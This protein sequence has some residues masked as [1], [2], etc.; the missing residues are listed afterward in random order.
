MR[1][2]GVDNNSSDL[3]QSGAPGTDGLQHDQPPLK[4]A[5]RPLLHTMYR[6]ALFPF[7]FT[8]HLDWQ[9]YRP[10]PIDCSTYDS[11]RWRRNR[12][13]F[14]LIHNYSTWCCCAGYRLCLPG[15][16]LGY[17]R[18]HRCKTRLE[19]EFCFSL[20]FIGKAN[21]QNFPLLSWNTF[22]ENKII[23]PKLP[24]KIYFRLQVYHHKVN[25]K[26]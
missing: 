13:M 21:P 5:G 3:E 15:L 16:E 23:K 26:W 9:L 6:T 14:S 25:K 17:L 4:A 11:Y 24:G 18:V 7:T 2:C 12:I 8:T 22:V 19:S 1:A 20:K 10:S